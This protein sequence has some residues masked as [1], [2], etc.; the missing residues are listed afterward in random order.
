MDLSAALHRTF[1]R[2][3]I[4]RDEFCERALKTKRSHCAP[5]QMS[6]K[7]CAGFNCA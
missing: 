2:P 6:G 3:R 1:K 5:V 4:G 7:E